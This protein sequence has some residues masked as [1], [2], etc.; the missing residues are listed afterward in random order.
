MQWNS[1]ANTLQDSIAQPPQTR[2]STRSLLSQV[3][4]IFDPLGL[5]GSIMAKTKLLIQTLWQQKI[6][7]DEYMPTN[8]YTEWPSYQED[9]ANLN[10][11][12]VERNILTYKNRVELHGFYNA[13]EKHT[14]NV[15]TFEIQAIHE[16][17]PPSYF[18]RNLELPR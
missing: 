6:S 4:Q 1:W 11:V 14:D 12:V 10:S 9:Y 8:L 16:S 17:Y 13:S 15:S 3:S 18:V 5:L 2:I 7:W